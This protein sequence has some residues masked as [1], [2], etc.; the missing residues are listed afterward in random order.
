MLDRNKCEIVITNE[1][2]PVGIFT[3]KN[4][5]ELVCDNSKVKK[6]ILKEVMSILKYK[7]NE[8]ESIYDASRLMDEKNIRRLPVIDDEG[9]MIGMITM[10]LIAKNK[11]FMMA[12]SMSSGIAGS[13][14]YS[15]IN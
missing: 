4:A 1:D 12:R 9:R 2:V 10:D 11:K 6:G 5:L 14:S 15:F 3:E 8:N 7:I 13:S